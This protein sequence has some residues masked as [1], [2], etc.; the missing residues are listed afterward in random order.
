M[1]VRYRILDVIL[2]EILGRDYY[3]PE[4][5]NWA[6]DIEDGW[7]IHLEDAQASRLVAEVE[8]EE[9]NTVFERELPVSDSRL[10]AD[11][12]YGDYGVEGVLAGAGISGGASALATRSIKYGLLSAVLGGIA[13]LVIGKMVKGWR[14]RMYS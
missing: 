13:G 8:D 12:Y 5:R 14:V 9:G 6:E 4:D 10:V 11:I 1:M 3:L 7:H 2:S